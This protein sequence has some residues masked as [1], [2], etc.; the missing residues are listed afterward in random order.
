MKTIRTLFLGIALLMT[1]TAAHALTFDFTQVLTGDTPN[2]TSPWLTAIFSDS[3]LQVGDADTQGVLLT[4]TAPGLVDTDNFVS[5]WAFNT[6]LGSLTGLQHQV[7][8]LDGITNLESFDFGIDSYN[9]GAGA[10]FDL[11]FQF[12]TSNQ[13][14]G[15]SRFEGGEL[16]SIFLYGVDGLTADSFYA[17]SSPES[18]AYFAEAHI[19]E[20]IGGDEGSAWVVPGTTP[21]PE[22]GTLLLLGAGFLGLAIYGKRRRNS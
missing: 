16:A 17:L 1:A 5:T 15:A 11:V 21:V 4:L 20:I 8:E 2:G 3:T 10:L 6:Q 14:G 7:T 22:P 12:V 18:K 13:G 9:A 19:Q